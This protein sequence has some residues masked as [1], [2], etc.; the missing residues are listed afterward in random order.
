MNFKYFANKLDCNQHL[1]AAILLLL[2]LVIFYRDVVFNGRTFLME[3]AAEGTMPSKGPYKYAG[4]TP[5]FVVND[6]SALSLQIEPFNRFLSTSIKKGEFPLW[7]PY[8]GLAGNPLM[9]DGQT[10]PFEP[11]Q[12]LFFFVPDRF[13]TYA[14]DWQLLVRYFLAGFFCYLF[15]RR[16]NVGFWGSITAGTLFMLSNYFV[17]YGNHPQVKTEILMPLVLY[18][19][20][21]LAD[22]VEDRKGIWL[23]AL[24]IG[25]AIVAAMPEATFFSLFLGTLWYFYKSFFT[26]KKNDNILNKF[27]PIL[28]RYVSSTILGFLISAA[29]LL[30]FLEYVSL[31]ASAHSTGNGVNWGGSSLPLWAI[32]SAILRVDSR[33]YIQF[34]VFALFVLVFSLLGIKDRSKFR[35]ATILFSVYAAFFILAMFNFPLTNWIHKVPVFDRIV[36]YKYPVIS[37]VFCLSMLSGFLV[38]EAYTKLSYRKISISLMILPFLFLVLPR[39]SD[40]ENFLSNLPSK[41]AIYVTLYFAVGITFAL[42]FLTFLVKADHL[43]RY[44]LQCI[45]LLMFVAEPFYWGG[46]I[47]RPNRYDPYFQHIPPFINYLK[48]DNE[49]YRIFSLGGVLYPNTSTAYRIFDVRYLNALVPKRAYDFTIRFITSEEPKSVRFTGISFPVSDRMFN[50]LNVKYILDRYVPNTDVGTCKKNL[51]SENNMRQPVFFNQELDVEQLV[52]NNSVRNVVLAHPRSKFDMPMT[53]PESPSTLDFSI[54][55]NP[56]VFQPDRGDGV[57]FTIRILDN[58][59]KD[60]SLLYSK[61]IDPKN[62]PCDRRWFDE[63]IPLDHWAG[64][65]IILKFSTNAGPMENANWDWAYWGDIRLNTGQIIHP[66]VQ[67]SQESIMELPYKTVHRDSDVEIYQNKNVYPRAFMVYDIVNASSFDQALDLLSNPDIDL[68]QTAIIEKFPDNVSAFVEKNE[69]K[70]SLASASVNQITSDGLEVEVETGSAGLLVVSEQYYPGWRAY[71]DGSETPIYA[72]DGIL[73]GVYLNKGKHVVIFKY[74]PLSFSIGLV[75]SIASLLMT[76]ACL[77]YHN[78]NHLYEEMFNC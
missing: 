65:E 71:I 64:K 41:Q 69:Q 35:S 54:G 7:N 30:P 27:K 13:W 25:W 70:L 16:L 29:Y 43:S 42:Y 6:P 50:L 74:R 18:G 48:N 1:L 3:T 62:D 37:I 21:R 2:I 76:V 31:A 34:G 39:L 8:A 75:I 11:I 63:S 44:F 12:F 58:K 17:T 53:I 46:Q 28:V 20:E 14:V 57:G 73:R 60:E 15:A 72:V 51:P 66:S 9:A 55:L 59:N 40:P 67:A 32:F 56:G 52:I 78:K 10:G 45:L 61:Y 19:Y 22:A 68:R 47:R 5:G 36:L 23:C 49:I 4:A 33:Y 38:D 26:Q 77:V 24:F